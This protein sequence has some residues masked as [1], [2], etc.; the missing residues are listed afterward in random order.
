MALAFSLFFCRHLLFE[1]LEPIQDEDH[2]SDGLKLAF[3]LF[4]SQE[5]AAVWRYIPDSDHAPGNISFHLYQPKW[6]SG[7]KTRISLNIDHPNIAFWSTR[8]IKQ[9]LSVRAPNGRV[10]PFVGDLPSS[11]TFR[12]KLNINLIAS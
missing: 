5:S 3:I 1:F 4:H 6:F 7:R 12:K 2:F 9:L 11:S 8:K 10:T